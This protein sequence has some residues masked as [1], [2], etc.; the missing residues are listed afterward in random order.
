MSNTAHDSA[1]RL[2]GEVL[3]RRTFAIISH[4]DA[5][6]TTLTEKL[7]LYGGAIHLAGSVKARRATRHAT[8]DWM[9]MEQERG[10][11]VTSSV[12]QFDYRG[13]RINL[14]DTPGHQDFSEDTYRTLVAADSAV[15]LL[16][17]RKGVEE[18]TRKLFNVCK[19]RRTPVFTL[20][21]KCDRP[22]EDPFRLLD[23]VEADLGVS[24][25]PITWPILDR[26]HFLGV[27]HRPTG[28]AI[29]F[30][31]GADHGQTEVRTD[32]HPL[33]SDSLADALGA[34]ITAQI[35]EEIELL[36]EAGA[37]FDRD[38]VL[39]GTLSPTFF[40]SALTNFGIEPFLETFLELAPAPPPRDAVE[41]SVDPCD[42]AFTSFVFK[43][44]ANLDPRHRDRI[45][46]IR[47][48]SGRFEAGMDV[49][50]QRSGQRVRLAQ[51]Q[52]FLAR[53]R[54][55]IEEAWPGDVVGIHDRGNLRIGDTLTAGSSVEFRDI[56]RFSPEHFARIHVEDPLRR[57]HLDNGLRQLGEEGAAQVFYASS[58]AGPAP[59]VGAVGPL[60]FD[61]LLHR[62]ESEYGVEARLERLPFTSARWITG[63]EASIDE[64]AAGYDR[65]LVH[66][67]RERPLILFES[68][69]SMQRTVEKGGEGI[70]FHAVAP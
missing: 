2:E 48:V 64:I 12:L 3:R 41:G 58:I 62:L 29:L 21:N 7:L 68:E 11:S 70:E 49:T 36:D 20:V 50:N 44:Q 31:R 52:S 53:D 56:P 14:L 61:V 38:A 9:K 37:T 59:I 66:D 23:D 63:P 22:G 40:G 18:Q 45:A 26:G 1:S 10:I 35:R 57:K 16:D 32:R 47:I 15:M 24:C 65:R 17:N 28:E 43:I 33:A 19:L 30:R 39:A 67:V 60:Q 13:L 34:E 51:P 46:F 8:S 25:Y 54:Q 4:P 42:E 69:W 5:G 6:K 55:A 27:V